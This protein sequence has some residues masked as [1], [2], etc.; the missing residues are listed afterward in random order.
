MCLVFTNKTTWSGNL[1]KH[2]VYL[3]LHRSLAE[4]AIKAER[5]LTVS[6]GLFGISIHFKF[7]CAN[8]VVLASQSLTIIIKISLTLLNIQATEDIPTNRQIVS[9]V[10]DFQVSDAALVAFVSLEEVL[11]IQ[12]HC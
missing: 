6:R 2:R 12:E 10:V 11:S 4:L 7:H 9:F 5:T 1:L 3:N 8:S